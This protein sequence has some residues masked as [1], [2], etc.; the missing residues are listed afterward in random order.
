MFCPRPHSLHL[1]RSPQLLSISRMSMALSSSRR[2]RL[3]HIIDGHCFLR[4][5][6]AEPGPPR[7]EQPV[8]EESVTAQFLEHLRR[9]PQR[10]WS[11]CETLDSLLVSSSSV[12]P[13]VFSQVTW[14]LQSYALGFSFF[15]YLHEKSHSLQR[16]EESLSYAFQSVVELAGRESESCDKLL[17]L[18]EVAKERK[19]P[20][21]VQAAKFLIRLFGRLG[22]MKQSV[23]VY[24]EL[25]PAAKNTHIR[26]VLI[27]VL[28]RDGLVDD[29]FKVLDEMLQRGSDFPPNDIT[30][31]IVFHA[32]SRG[33]RRGRRITEE[34]IVGLVSRFGVHGVF[35]S[36]IWLTRFI[37]SLC[38]NNRTDIAWDMLMEL[39]NQ[40]ARL[41]APPF[42]ALLTRLGRN[43][44]IE[45][46]NAVSEKMDEMDIRPDVVTFGILINTLCKCRRVDEALEVFEQ[47]RG[48]ETNDGD[49]IKADVINFNTLIDGL[50]K[51]GRLKEAEELLMKMK[52][53]EGCP[54]NTITYNCLIDGYCRAGQLETAKTVVSRMK[55]ERIRPNVVTLNIIV[56]G[57]CKH[58]GV[59]MAVQFFMDM[60]REGLKGNAVTYTTLIHAYCNVNNIEKAMHWFHQ[61]SESGCPPDA[62]VY[63]TLISG[64]CQARRDRDAISVVE[65]LKEAGF[66]LDVLAYNMLVGLFCSKNKPE[67][68]Y[69]MLADME[70][71]GLKPDSVTYNTLI[72]F[73]S[74]HQDFESIERMMEKM[75]QAGL[76]PTVVT[77]GAIIEAYCSN[78][79]T[80]EAIKLFKDM[81][82]RSKVMPNAVIY[83]I[84]INA[85]C[86]KGSIDR[87]LCLKDEM[88]AKRVRPNVETYNALF[89]GLGEKNRVEKV[90]ELMDEMVENSCEPDYITCEVL[91]E[92]LSA[93]G[94]IE[95]LKKFLQ[96]SKVFTPDD[97]AAPLDAFKC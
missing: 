55:D 3:L 91:M 82:L 71:S 43:M 58:H 93:D 97:R 62:K 64:L 40:G 42:N 37:N 60:Q 96:G 92:L 65:K 5:I 32:V 44:E 79:D 74:K 9:I 69:E 89:K 16:R 49:V 77:Y 78:G 95:K 61:M 23:I 84:L 86:K 47:M 1:P 24:E 10:D 73:F 31:D 87:A 25:N 72:S 38:K 33:D 22:M 20:L 54:A 36:S 45:R 68:V 75:R 48:M 15:D 35:P 34:E 81:G 88:R 50:C 7:S 17:Q 28:L 83:N 41:G 39:M 52:T 80:D 76:V 27:D 53:E 11:S 19:I 85:Y 12:S 57:M 59:G 26:N 67:K 14:R 29:A 90:F 21:N 30:G 63:Y 8:S 56:G 70:G 66:S 13:R 51:L 94:H 4:R 2:R 46:V 18:Y 6:S